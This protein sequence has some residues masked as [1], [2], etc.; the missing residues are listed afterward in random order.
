MQEASDTYD[1][2]ICK[3]FLQDGVNNIY[4][5]VKN[6]GTEPLAGKARA[7]Y[8][9]INLLYM[10]YRWKELKAGGDTVIE[11]VG[12]DYASNEE[13]YAGIPSGQVGCTKMAYNLT[14]V[15]DPNIH[16]CMMGL[17]ASKNGKFIS[18]P[19]EFT[20]DND[21]W[22]YLRNNPQIAYNNII[23]EKRPQMH[24]IM[25]NVDIGN[26]DGTSR[27]YVMNVSV[28]TGAETLKNTKLYL[29]CTDQECAFSYTK[30]MDGHTT[31]YT[32]QETTL[33]PK[34]SGTMNFAIDMYDYQNTN[35][36]I[37]VE[38]F[39]VNENDDIMLPDVNV[40]HSSRT[41]APKTATLLGDFYLHLG[42]CQ[43]PDPDRL[44]KR[45]GQTLIIHD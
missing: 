42:N 41:M 21:L 43:Y 20:G 11:L 16:Y 44:M 17:V 10:P 39:V 8:A 26:L 25:K 34:F 12:S 22:E 18:L 7:F 33:S 29:Q 32:F 15:E 13:N 3:K 23:I 40:V 36:V 6:L 30:T 5:R 27:R 45:N 1:S 38:N 9:P 24:T 35:A 31:D 4:V 14:A 28:L 2:Y 37:R 19:K